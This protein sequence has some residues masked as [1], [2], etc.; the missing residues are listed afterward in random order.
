[1]KAR[2]NPYVKR[3]IKA[4]WR[5]SLYAQVSLH[6]A[7]IAAN[8]P[9][10]LDAN[11]EAWLK[12][13]RRE[14]IRIILGAG[15]GNIGDD[16]MLDRLITH[17]DE[18]AVILIP[19]AHHLQ[20]LDRDPFVSNLRRHENRR[21]LVLPGQP[22][23]S[24]NPIARFTAHRRFGTLCSHADS[25]E[26]I[27]ADTMDGGNES[28]SLTRFDLLSIATSFGLR[29]RVY[30]FS[31]RAGVPSPIAKRMADTSRTTQFV[32]RDPASARRIQD[33][34][35]LGI[36]QAAD[37]VF[38][39]QATERPDPALV[40][41]VD[42]AATAPAGFAIVNVSGLV[43]KSVEPVAE[44]GAVVDALHEA[45]LRIL[46]LPH[47]I[48]EADSDLPAVRAV[49]NAYANQDDYLVADLLTP[50]QVAWITNRSELIITGR[51]HLAILSLKE[52]RT[53]I[54]LSTAGKVRGML[55]LFDLETLAVEPVTG[56]GQALTEKVQLLLS[57]IHSFRAR[58]QE[59]LPQVRAFSN[60]NFRKG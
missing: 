39:L 54:V 3:P 56:Y 37:L 50:R 53:P 48:R 27:G 1:M 13:N 55:Q 10:S 17:N 59:Q 57:E 41:W 45:G 35:A 51:M 33:D 4:F 25:F 7:L 22:F 19:E 5:T 47:V 11:A 8:H 18:P 16:A 9:A 31:W 36:L 34:G 24:M 52:G 28:Q 12:D 6:S 23:L 32:L 14:S 29:T 2:N 58:V 43:S 20:D 30:G 21:F 26:I 60:L 42:S 44:Y 38:G 49:F 40:R 15:L 46:F